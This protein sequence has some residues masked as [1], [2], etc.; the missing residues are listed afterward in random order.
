[1]F[2]LK[3]LIKLIQL[4]HTDEGTASLALGFSLALLPAFAG[5]A[6]V[7]GLLTLLLVIFFRIQMG[8]YFLG[9]FFFSLVSLLLLRPMNSLGYQILTSASLKPIWL[10]AS[11]WPLMHWLNFNN[12]LVVGGQIY[13]L[14]ALPFVF[15]FLKKIIQKYKTTVVVRFRN[16]KFYRFFERSSLIIKYNNVLKTLKN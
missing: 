5:F 7:L 9:Y 6:S 8:A 4:L 2:I 3:Q 16:T 15:I 14:I 12:T 11:K 13:A 1:M 10:S